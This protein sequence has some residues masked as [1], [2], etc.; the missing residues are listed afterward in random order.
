[1]DN[2]SHPAAQFV[3]RVIMETPGSEEAAA[4]FFNGR[5]GFGAEKWPPWCDLP[6]SAVYTILTSGAC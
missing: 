6:M 5:G 4:R 1:M 3:R 2:K